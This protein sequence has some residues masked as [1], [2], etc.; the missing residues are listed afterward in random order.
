MRIGWAPLAV[1]LSGLLLSLL[2]FRAELEADMGLGLLYALRGP[3]SPPD[4]VA[5]VGIDHNSAARLQ[6]PDDPRDWPRGLHA[7]MIRNARSNAAEL[8]AF[9]IFFA[10]PSPDPKADQAMADAMGE[11]ENVVLTDYL[12]PRHI[13]AGVYVESVME[14]AAELAGAAIAT[15]PFLLTKNSGGANAF[16]TFFGEED[17]RSTLPTLLFLAY[18]LRLWSDGL[19]ELV[20]PS[21]PGLAALIAGH[22]PN[23]KKRLDFDSLARKLADQL[24]T[25]PDLKAAL[26]TTIADR[27]LPEPPR[28]ILRSLM[29]ILHGDEVR[30]FNHYGPAR[31]FRTIPYHELVTASPDAGAASLRNKILLVGYLEDFQP[32]TTEGL[33]YTPYSSISSVELAATAL[34]NLLEDKW[35]HPAFPPLHE[36][37]WLLAWGGALGFCARRLSAR[38]GF[39]LILAL[40]A[41]YLASAWLLFRVQGAWLP[42]V[43]PLGWQIP[44]ALLASLALNYLR[45]ARREQTMQSVIQRF[46]PV[47]V[48]SQLTRHEDSGTLPT[49]GRLARGLCLA[50]DAGRYTAL[51][52]TMEPMALAR[53]MN[54]YY[55]AI[56]EPVTR[57]GGWISDVVGDAMLAI[58][59]TDGD[60]CEA[61]YSALSA[62]L[63]IREAVRRFEKSHGLILPIRMGLHYGDLRIGYVGT[64]DRGEIRAV[65]DTVNTAARLEAL[66]KLLGSHILVSEQVLE[67]L[68]VDRVRPLGEFLLAGKSRP[69]AVAELVPEPEGQSGLDELHDRFREALALFAGERWSEAYAAF[70]RLGLQFPDDGP[71]R[72]Y[73]RTCQSYLADPALAAG[74]SGIQVEKPE[75]ARLFTP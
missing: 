55:E 53:L 44:A 29:R 36:A 12:K 57:R 13:H 45:G 21:D 46:I 17:K 56:F 52:E 6:A 24:R 25:R 51:A 62:A 64:S 74:R 3:E 75:S 37:L 38:R 5:I 71:T 26:E 65:G 32:E 15:A 35:V 9:N 66:N 8:V 16:L 1:A 68:A 61:R 60:A 47:D 23:S 20:L 31:T 18:S 59:I 7:E 10:G 4:N 72:F 50:T 58:W 14:P 43:I 11:A 54:S 70:T 22:S 33:F 27:D 67:G 2:P 49:Y 40:G 41:G 63:E 19:A 39:A 73:Q 28:R 34:A 30:Y 69:V 42:I 48:F